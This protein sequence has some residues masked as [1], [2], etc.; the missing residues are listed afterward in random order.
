MTRLNITKESKASL[1]NLGGGVHMVNPSFM[2]IGA[3]KGGTT[4]LHANLCQHPAIYTGVRK[5]INFFNLNYGKGLDWYN[6][7]FPAYMDQKVLGDFSPGYFWPAEVPERVRKHYPKTKLI[8][9]LRNPVE[10]T[11]SAFYHN[12]RARRVSPNT[13]LKDLDK[14]HPTFTIGFYDLH[15]E[16]WLKLFPPEQ[17]L[18]LFYEEDILT[19]RVQTLRKV[20]SFIGVGTEFEP[21]KLDARQNGRYS[22]LAMRI[23]YYSPLLAKISERALPSNMLNNRRWHIP[24]DHDE[25]VELE[26]LFSKHDER[27]SAMLGRTLPWQRQQARHSGVLL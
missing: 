15:L 18:I 1:D 3:P 20:L 2:V 17:F 16:R 27:L 9:S 8:V 21:R 10:R 23:N 14:G 24:I 5:E 19:N 12:I 22:H 4:W 26:C 13:R 6:R 7:Q 11:I 25:M